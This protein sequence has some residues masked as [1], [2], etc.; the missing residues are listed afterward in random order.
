MINQS[1]AYVGIA[2]DAIKKAAKL[3]PYGRRLRTLLSENHGLVPQLGA[4]MHQHQ[5]YRLAH[6]GLF[7]CLTGRVAHGMQHGATPLPP[8]VGRE[9][10]AREFGSQF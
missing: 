9:G 5:R 8:P 3:I 1:L 10:V 2:Q 7:H 6:F 4:R